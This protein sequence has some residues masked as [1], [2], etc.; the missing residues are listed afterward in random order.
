MQAIIL[1][2]GLGTRLKPLTDTMP[3][4]MAK[5]AGKPLIDHAIDYLISQGADHIIVNVHHFGKLLRDYLL[6]NNYPVHIEV[7]DE[8]TELK[9]TGGALVHALPLMKDES[10]ILIF[11]TDILT[12]LNLKDLYRIHQNSQNDATLIVQDRESSRKL[13]FSENGLLSGWINQNTGERKADDGPDK[14]LLAFS[15]IHLLN[16]KL[17]RAFQKTYGS[18]PF[19]IIS[20]YLE[21]MHAFKIGYLKAPKDIMWLETGNPQRLENAGKFMKNR[22]LK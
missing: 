21:V 17:I 7:S 15:G 2:A 14:K 5:C 20:A 16:L 13:A 8:T 3:K 1:A 19:S 9:D 11:N 18:R 10:D 6:K 22:N 4:A 12:D